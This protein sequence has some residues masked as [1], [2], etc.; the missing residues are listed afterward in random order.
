[1]TWKFSAEIFAILVTS[2]WRIT[3]F[4]IETM[5][6]VFL[7]RMEVSGKSFI[8]TAI[9]KVKFSVERG[10]SGNG[11]TLKIGVI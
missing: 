7:S 3:E 2:F 9:I 1:M 4:V 10:R 6:I 11:A 8:I 5:G